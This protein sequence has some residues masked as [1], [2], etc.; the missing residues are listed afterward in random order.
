MVNKYKKYRFLLNYGGDDME[1]RP[2][3]SQDDG[4]EYNAVDDERYFL[5]KFSGKLTFVRGEFDTIN[6]QPFDTDYRIKLQRKEYNESYTTIWNGIFNKTDCN[7][8]VDRRIVEVEVSAD[9]FYK[10]ILDNINK[11]FDLI[12]LGVQKTEVEYVKQPLIQVY[13]RWS[14]LITNFY[15]GQSFDSDVTPVWSDEELTN[16]YHFGNSISFAKILDTGLSPDISGDYSLTN[17]F[18]PHIQDDDNYYFKYEIGVEVVFHCNSVEVDDFDDFISIW[19][20]ANGNTYEVK[21]VYHDEIESRFS[22]L[23]TQIIDSFVIPDSGDLT[24]VSGAT[25]TNNITFYASELLTVNGVIPIHKPYLRAQVWTNPGE[26]PVYLARTIKVDKEHSGDVN[27]P[28][29]YNETDEIELYSLTTDSKTVIKYGHFYARLLTDVTIGGD[30]KDMPTD[31]IT[32][33][34]YRKIKPLNLELA[35]LAGEDVYISSNEALS[36]GDFGKYPEDAI[37]SPGLY[38]QE[39]DN[40]YTNLPLYRS[41]W[42]NISLWFELSPTI[43]INY[44]LYQTKI[45]LRDAY[46]GSDIIKAIVNEIDPEFSHANNYLY[47][48]FLYDTNNPVTGL[49]NK[50]IAFTAKSNIL[51]GAYDTAASRVRI[52]LRELLDFYKYAL[53]VYWHVDINGRFILEHDL[54]YHNGGKYDGTLTSY[55]LTTLT[56]PR[57]GRKWVYGTNKFTYRK[58]QIPEIIRTRW[59]DK[60]SPIFEGDD[61]ELIN[62]YVDKGNIKEANIGQFTSDIEYML[63]NTGD[64]SKNGFA[65]F[66]IDI[67]SIP[68][69]TFETGTSGKKIQNGGLSLTVLHDRYFKNPLP[70]SMAK[71]NGETVHA[72]KITRNKKQD[73]IVPGKISIDL[74]K[75]IETQLGKGKPE[76]ASL[77]ITTD[78]LKITVYHDTE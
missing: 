46:L 41:D 35:Q 71:I 31:D 67:D 72:E 9:D 44:I 70:S 30:L 50:P 66:E 33:A 25:N 52:K 29:T 19:Q 22:V 4:L 16:N 58:I 34:L 75:L 32:D 6:A 21:G 1:V 73:V 20:D 55:D 78:E 40:D 74:I 61:I 64:I 54:Y 36:S 77:S 43:N 8:D 51:A 76:S 48:K 7:F 38:Y 47:S 37:I 5:T 11:E 59:M 12:E 3:Y 14:P 56:N 13:R 39:P 15:Q 23:C 62:K 49:F 63:A 69:Y 24:H 18:R 57:N 68:F 26:E 2:I 53:N 65:V 27:E 45:K 10:K 60:V 28:R 17:F 42:K